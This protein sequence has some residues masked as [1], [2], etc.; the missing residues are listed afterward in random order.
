MHRF[1]ILKYILLLFVSTSSSD[2]DST[3][4]SLF[5]NFL[6]LSLGTD[7]LPNIVCLAIIDGLFSEIYL[8]KLFQGF[9]ILRRDEAELDDKVPRSHFHAILD[10]GDSLTMKLIS[11]SNLTGV[12]SFP[13]TII[14]WLWGRRTN[15]W[16]FRGIIADY[17]C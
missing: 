16:V 9:I 3:S 11:F 2:C 6:S 14:N 13:L 17:R 4:T 8:F 15:V 1:V 5:D 10:K 7:Y 12:Y